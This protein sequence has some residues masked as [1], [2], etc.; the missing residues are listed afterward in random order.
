MM[1]SK[2]EF[3][4][5]FQVGQNQYTYFIMAIDASGIG[6]VLNKIDDKAFSYSIILA[7]LAIISW[8]ISFY[9]GTRFQQIKNKRLKLEYDNMDMR[10]P[11]YPGIEGD[12]KIIREKAVEYE[13]IAL[14]DQCKADTMYSCINIFVCVGIVFLICYEIWEMVVRSTI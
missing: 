6:F 10:E 8:G 3:F 1:I 11:D 12:Q 7:C 4:K 5:L 13:N 14:S 2:E 9:C